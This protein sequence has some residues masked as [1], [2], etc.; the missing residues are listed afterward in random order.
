M[1]QCG[2]CP[3]F[4][5]DG[6]RDPA[7][8]NGDILTRAAKDAWLALIE[9]HKLTVPNCKNVRVTPFHL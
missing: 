3:G 2:H 9:K 4:R 8:W 7:Q 6:S 5:L 1:Q